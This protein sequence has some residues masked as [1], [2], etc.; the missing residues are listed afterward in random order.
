ML[1]N[2]PSRTRH[3]MFQYEATSVRTH[4]LLEIDATQF[5]SIQASL[6]AWAERE[7]RRTP[8]LV[9]R[10]GCAGHAIPVGIRGPERNQ[11]WAA[12]C[13]PKLVKSILSPPQL[14]RRTVPAFRREAVPA[15]GSLQLLEDRWIGFDRSWGPGGSVGFE[16]ATGS[17]VAKPKSDLDIV[18]YCDRR[19][20]TDEAKWLCGLASNLPAAVDI[21]VETPTCGF[22]LSEYASQNP[23]PI[24]LRTPCGVRL[25][26]DPWSE[27]GASI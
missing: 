13:E 2:V 17:H 24:L 5:L 9:V 4:D 15:F 8:F 10:R 1:L 11:R 21:R 22:S 12:F 18:I 6:P 7:L 26:A 3:R 25:G 20:T 14:L 27:T 19:I 16:L 23:G